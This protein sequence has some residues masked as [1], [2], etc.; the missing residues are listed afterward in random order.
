MKPN[1]INI[2][3]LKTIKSWIKLK[4]KLKQLLYIMFLLKRNVTNSKRSF[5]WS[6]CNFIAKIQLFYH[7]VVWF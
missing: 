5:Q 1:K 4:I 2:V 3:S 6:V 7:T